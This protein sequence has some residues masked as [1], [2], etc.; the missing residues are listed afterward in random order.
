MTLPLF[1]L[2]FGGILSQWF[3]R[4]V[5]MAEAATLPNLP[6][7]PNPAAFGVEIRKAG[8]CDEDRFRF[9][10]NQLLIDAPPRGLATTSSAQIYINGESIPPTSSDVDCGLKTYTQVSIG[11][12]SLKL[13][14]G[15]NELQVVYTCNG[16]L[17]CAGAPQVIVRKSFVYA[18]PWVFVWDGAVYMGSKNGATRSEP[19]VDLLKGNH[20]FMSSLTPGQG[21]PPRFN[22]ARRNIFGI[23][24]S[25]EPFS[26]WD[27]EMEENANA[28]DELPLPDLANPFSVPT[29]L[30]GGGTIYTC[31]GPAVFDSRQSSVISGACTKALNGP[32][33][34]WINGEGVVGGGVTIMV[35]GSAG[36]LD[37]QHLDLL[38]SNDR[39]SSLSIIATN[40]QPLQI[41][42]NIVFHSRVGAIEVLSS[43]SGPLSVPSLSIHATNAS[44]TG[45]VEIGR[46]VS[47]VSG[48][49]HADTINILGGS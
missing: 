15:L 46:G 41:S 16:Q 25:H 37:I 10:T 33:L 7:P 47:E 13:K 35:S 28:V 19:S 43:S 26:G 20:D 4:P 11:T 21:Q 31:T 27:F 3:L 44:G 45:V 22:G 6:P 36:S 1:L 42:G 34:Q 40:G 49:I 18:Y 14:R 12:P 32:D 48:V 39:P 30:S 5:P 17:E 2:M 29:T 24:Q 8:D 23:Y 9:S 38:P